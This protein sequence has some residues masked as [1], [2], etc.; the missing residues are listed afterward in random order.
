MIVVV[1]Y[2]HIFIKILSDL[3]SQDWE[4]L[5]V[6]EDPDVYNFL[7]SVCKDTN[8][9]IKI[10]FDELDVFRDCYIPSSRNVRILS[11]FQQIHDLKH[12]MLS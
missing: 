10:F 1:T 5:K 9:M 8:Y 12:V 6:S 7:T 2:F 11:A 3:I 4:Q